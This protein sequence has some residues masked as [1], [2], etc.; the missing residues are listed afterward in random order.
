M[1]LLFH[2]HKKG[3]DMNL[4]TPSQQKET[5]IDYLKTVIKKI[6]ECDYVVDAKVDVTLNHMILDGQLKFQEYNIS[7]RLK[8]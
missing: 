5:I 6:E 4:I 7:I 2:P 3:K 8:E 1:N